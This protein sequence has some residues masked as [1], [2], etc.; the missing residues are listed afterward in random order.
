MENESALNETETQEFSP[1]FFNRDLS[2]VDF[3][4]RVL[5][6]GLRKDLPLFERFRFLSIVSSNFDEFFKVRVA[7]VRRAQQ[8]GRTGDPAGL[9]PAE[10]LNAISEKVRSIIRRQDACYSDDIFPGLAAGGLELVRP[11]S[12]TVS[13]MDY[14]E[15]F[16][17][18]QIYPVLT[19]LRI[20]DDRTEGV[21][22]EGTRTEG[23]QPIPFFESGCINTAYLL[24]PENV[25]DT[26]TDAE[27]IV[28]VQLPVSLDRIIWLPADDNKLR[29]ALLDDVV[30]TWGG[31]LFPG[32]HIQESLLF[33]VNRDADFSVDERR[34][35]DFIEAMEEVLEDR[36]KSEVV[37]MVHSP[38]SVRLR[39]K[40]AKRFS[41]ESDALYE[42][43]GP[44]NAGNLAELAGVAGLEHL[45]EKAWKI[46][47]VPG[48]TGDI[49]VW[50]RLSYGDVMIHFPYQSFDP[51]IRFFQEAAADPQVI[52]IKTTLYRT[53]SASPIVRA[54]EK[55]A[56]NGK[57]VTA[58]VELKARFD[59]ERNIS[60]AHRLEKAGVIVVYGL[61]KLKVHAKVTLVLRRE[62]DRL[63]RYVH[64]STGNYNDKTAKLYEDICLFTCR[65]EIAFDTNLLFNMITGYS[66]KQT[67]QLLAIAPY[68]IKSRL[69]DLIENEA[70]RAAQQYPSRIMIKCNSLT[71]TAMI[72]ALY[73]ASQAGVNILL[74]I[75]GICALV[76]GIPGLSENI[77]VISV[78]DYYL[79][80]SRIYY[81]ANG[82]AG[83]LYLSSADLMPR[84]LD[85]RI[86]LL[87][88]VLDPKIRAELID[89]LSA[90]FR[91]NC[92]AR[93]LDSSGRWKRLAPA[94]GEAQFRIQKDMLQRAANESARP[95]PVKQEFTVRRS[96]PVE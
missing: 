33:K 32:Y 35:E 37:R 92:Q 18:G 24:K 36:E 15:S 45:Q 95:E 40:L 64:L 3:N 89:R 84:N 62:H 6:E 47:P 53:G 82:G 30:L 71:D 68:D 72:D 41:L 34:D 74:C 10:Q 91:D 38:G 13:Q 63:K 12:Y 51:V 39:D 58:L 2:W 31:Y 29:W 21:H 28:M 27:Y 67:M 69:L 66:Q 46:H 55:A 17:I 26:G 52:S 9:S 7:A 4:G 85:R 23:T 42:Y 16:F 14:L 80:H 78:I 44:F 90:Y 43:R 94:P 87:F 22:A 79:E 81:F 5:E 49:P 48:F 88:P 25:S 56:L 76:P 61:S 65:E 50:D 11:D 54:L 59:E 57:H 60:W 1:V 75:R 86:E 73:R 19:P 83:E 8:A 20:E 93:E 96:P 77:R 70:K